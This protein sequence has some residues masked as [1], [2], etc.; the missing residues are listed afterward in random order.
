VIHAKPF[1]GHHF[2]LYERNTLSGWGRRRPGVALP[3]GGGQAG[4]RASGPST[5]PPGGCGRRLV[6]GRHANHIPPRRRRGGGA[7]PPATPTQ[8]RQARRHAGE[9]R[10]AAALR[11][12]W[13]LLFCKDKNPLRAARARGVLHKVLPVA[14]LVAGLK[15]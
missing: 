1:S 10:A 14:A 11:G 5:A 3:A 7:P 6:H 12:E 13:K 15:G 2:P 8:A 4:S 9:T